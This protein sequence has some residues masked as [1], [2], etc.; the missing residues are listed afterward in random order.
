MTV[1]TF[2]SE[3]ERLLREKPLETAL[4]LPITWD[5]A[6]SFIP[7]EEMNRYLSDWVASR[8][9]KSI[10]E[11]AER[12]VQ[13]D[14]HYHYKLLL[15]QDWAM[16]FAF[17][18]NLIYPGVE[19]QRTLSGKGV[20]LWWIE[21]GAGTLDEARKIADRYQ[22]GRIPFT[23]RYMADDLD[24]SPKVLGDFVLQMIGDDRGWGE[25]AYYLKLSYSNQEVDRVFNLNGC[26]LV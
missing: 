5:Y 8:D 12:Q 21:Q 14:P 3:Q 15:A 25:G 13:R 24:L 1:K 2:T 6:D 20:H 17:E 10:R 26:G 16:D 4:T 23:A 11:A 18:S 9:E 22:I 19:P 7:V